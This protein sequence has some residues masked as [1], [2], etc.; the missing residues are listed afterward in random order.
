MQL[1]RGHAVKRI[2][3]SSL[4][5]FSASYSFAAWDKGFNFRTTS[6][7]VTDGANTTYVLE[8]DAY[9]TV[10]NGVTFGWSYSACLTD[11]GGGGRDRDNVIDARLAGMNF[12]ANRDERCTFK[13]DLPAAGNYIITLGYGDAGGNTKNNYIVIK[14]SGTTVLTLS[15]VATAA[16]PTFGDAVGNTYNAATW[17]G[18]QTTATETFATTTFDLMIGS[19]A[20]PDGTDASITHLFISQVGSSAFRGILATPGS[21]S[22]RTTA[23]S[24]SLRTIP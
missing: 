8:G 3:A 18:S 15:G 17:P 16:T 21:N 14:D 23:G 13:V 12:I 24:N 1:H 19:G 10:R 2:I 20:T 22:I 5:I 9:P 6:G 11:F 7:Y 4:L